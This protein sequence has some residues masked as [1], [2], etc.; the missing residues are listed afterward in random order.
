MK[1]AVN[2][3][4]LIDNRLEG[5]GWFAYET[6]I[7]MTRNHPEHQF[8]FLFDRPYSKK[9]IFSENIIPIII[10]PPARHPILWFIWFE[11][12]VRKILQKYNIDIFL[13]PDGYISLFTR[14]KQISV[15]HDINFEYYPKQFRLSHRIYL[16]YYF[17]RFAKRANRI[18]TVSE[19]SKQDIIKNYKV[20]STKIDVAY[21]GANEIY[22]ALSNEEKKLA[23]QKFASGNDY[24]VY[25]GALSPRKNVARLLE[26]FDKFKLSNNDAKLL[27]V[28]A[29][30]FN[31]KDIERAYKQMKFGNDVIFAGRLAPGD[32][33]FALGGSI[34]LLLVSYFEGFGIPIIEAMNSDVAVITSNITSMPEIAGNA[35]L[36]VDPFSVENICEAM[37]GIYFN[38]PLR[39]SLIEKGRIRKQIFNWDYTAQKVWESIEKCIKE[40]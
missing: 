15:I 21:N 20:N 10:N 16:L 7:R 17:K 37:K 18:I 9:F 14:T 8:Y 11:F 22:H 34:A 30:L 19:F 39:N 31:T 28:G 6:L 32:I 1:I 3:R 26:A 23:K 4:L 40:N 36:F 5:I 24:F 2:T 33:E 29:K 38:E 25:I 13:S 35:A 27:I 12:S